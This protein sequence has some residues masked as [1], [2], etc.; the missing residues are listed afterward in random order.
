MKKVNIGNNYFKCSIYFE[1][2]KRAA[3]FKTALPKIFFFQI[4]TYPYKDSVL[5]YQWF[6]RIY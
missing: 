5:P 2:K 3:F 4:F 6:R 1:N